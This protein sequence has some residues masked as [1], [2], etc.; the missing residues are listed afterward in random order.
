VV[1]DV[2]AAAAVPY[3]AVIRLS[4]T[5]SKDRMS[6]RRRSVNSRTELPDDVDNE[7]KGTDSSPAASV[8]ENSEPIK[9]N[10]DSKEMKQL[11]SGSHV[12]R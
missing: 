2:A 9:F 11:E 1:S 4:L 7:A 3:A 12:C 6:F 8:P 10:L 5:E